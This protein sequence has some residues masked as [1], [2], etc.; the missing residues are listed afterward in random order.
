MRLLQG[1]MDEIRTREGFKRAVLSVLQE[2]GLLPSSQKPTLH[3][4]K[5]HLVKS[6][7]DED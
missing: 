6:E 4:A 7:R 5:P 3:R 2:Q 1:D